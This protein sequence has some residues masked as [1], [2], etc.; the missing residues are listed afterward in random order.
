MIGNC[1]NV[2]VSKYLSLLTKDLITGFLAHSVLT[3]KLE[4]QNLHG[5][6]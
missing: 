3:D 1:E 6:T 2:M 4:T 5:K